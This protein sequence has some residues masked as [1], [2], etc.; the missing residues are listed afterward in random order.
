[1]VFGLLLLQTQSQAEEE[2]R[3]GIRVENDSHG[4]L[5]TS[6]YIF[7]ERFCDLGVD[8]GSGEVTKCV[9]CQVSE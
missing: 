2:E 5:I 9:E 8:K 7:G 1:M 6:L 4:H 3:D